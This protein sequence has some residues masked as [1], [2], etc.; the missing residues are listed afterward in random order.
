MKRAKLAGLGI[1]AL[2]LLALAAIYLRGANIPVLESRGVVGAQ[3]RQLIFIALGLSLIV[4]LPVFTLLFLFVWKYREGAP[5]QAKY[6]PE[7]DRNRALETAWWLIPSLLILVLSVI[8]WRS[9]HSLDPYKPLASSKKPLTIQVVSLDWKWLFMYPDQH[10]ASV[11]TLQIPV[12]TPV[13]FE[14][15]SDTVMN[16]FWIPQLGGQVYAMP[17]MV[18]RLHLMATSAGDYRGSSANIS[19][20]GFAGMTF[21]AHAGSAAD[22]AA[23]LATAKRAPESLSMRNYE[24][25]ARPSQNNPPALY[26]AV[27][28]GLYDTI[29]MKYMVPGADLSQVT[30]EGL[31]SHM[32]TQ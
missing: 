18:T 10:V 16:S 20:T 1:A 5:K 22:F 6:S 26:A 29:V 15:T 19:G 31:H 17:G 7:L 2:G 24:K 23:W 32:G 27:D 14:I 8:T 13:N 11:N 30:T 25:L 21:T 4:V 3:E 12:D 9:S 28:D